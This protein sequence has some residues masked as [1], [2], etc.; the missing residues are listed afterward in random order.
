MED[1]FFAEQLLLRMPAKSFSTY[2]D[3]EQAHLG[4]PGLIGAIYLAS[5]LFYHCLEQKAFL[6]EQLSD[7]EKVT[8]QKYI[9]RSCFRSTPFGLFAGVS[10]INWGDQTKLDVQPIRP[11][12]AVV[13]PDQAYV[14]KLSEELLGAELAGGVLFETNPTLY[15]LLDEYRFIT[16][17]TDGGD[18]SR[19][20]LLQ[21]ADYSTVLKELAA[22]CMT[23]RSQGDIVAEICRLANCSAAIGEDYFRFLS[24]EQFLVRRCRA[25]INGTGYL[26]LLLSQT[27][28]TG[29]HSRRTISMLQLLCELKNAKALGATYFKNINQTLEQFIAPQAGTSSNFLNVILNRKM[30]AGTLCSHWQ[31][32]I[33]DALF[34]LD[35]LCPQEPVPGMANFVRSFQKDFEGQMLSLLY[36]LDPEV[37]IGYV[38]D[39]PEKENQLLETLHIAARRSPDD[40]HSWTPSHRFLLEKWH[41]SANAPG[42]AI[43]I[44]EDEL[45]GL[46]RRGGNSGMLGLTVLFRIINDQVYLESAGGVNAPALMGRFTVADPEIAAAARRMAREQEAANPG[47]IFAE[48]L[49]LSGPHTDNVNRRETI[50]SY[51]LPLTAVSTLPEERQIA[52]SDLKIRVEN[53]KVLLYSETRRKVIVPRLSSAYNH[54][55]DKLPL[56]RFL[57]DISYQY[58][59]TALS[60]DLRQ[61]FPG[62]SYYPRV[63]YKRAILQ[64]ATWVLS[65]KQI[66]S[67]EINEE[68]SFGAAIKRLIAE[69]GLPPVFSLTEGDQQL[70]FFRDRPADMLFFSACVKHKKEAVLREH[71]ME[72]K[73]SAFVKNR[74]GEGFTCQFNTFLLPDQPVFLSPLSKSPI[75]PE[76]LKRKFMP[77]SEWLYLKIYTSKIGSTRLLLT[78][79][80]L[81]RRKYCCGPVQ[82]WFFIR[83][84]DHAPHIRLRLQIDPRDISEILIAFKNKLEDGMTQHVIREYQI[85]VYSRELER[86]QAGG[87]TLTENFFWASSELTVGL[88]KRPNGSNAPFI[89]QA[90]LSTVWHMILEFIPDE[91]ARLLF[92]QVSYQ[93]FFTE[94]EEK[95]LRVEMDKKYRGLAAD[96]RRVLLDPFFYRTAGLVRGS[97]LF[98]N[99]VKALSQAAQ[100][101]DCENYLRSIIH[102]HVNRLFTADARKQEMIVY[103]LLH[104]F[105]LGEKGRKKAKIEQ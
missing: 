69:T 5:P 6:Y 95:M 21:S 99:A 66:K 42:A 88:L 34:A 33:R 81:V 85:D 13:L 79:L 41:N 9:N 19:R 90:A 57:A 102:M 14:L 91:D 16:T 67:V 27:G 49:H 62:L 84:D 25:N 31:S 20:Y 50:W 105:F 23:A 32:P 77:G 3:D 55:I 80:P 71:L 98:I 54:S 101:G 26:E 96:I 87:I 7:K 73:E 86:Y 58:G 24:A 60:L 100:T 56:F 64:L 39:E 70:V 2:H 82:K 97:R 68:P 36:A 72:T 38:T 44:R 63:E 1:Y 45:A 83:Y 10:L 53:N 12:N 103:Y 52:L 22:Y 93:Q 94:F 30:E 35:I 4:N 8:L 18:N 15:R 59:R 78:I 48:I 28:R 29:K 46:E 76:K 47:I 75:K 43:R 40:A 74:E 104:K 61:F 37:G 11:D 51:D 92:L 65:E 89:Y 17:E